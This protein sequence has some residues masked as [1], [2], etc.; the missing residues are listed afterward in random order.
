MLK[1]VVALVILASL[2]FWA[3]P[4]PA[5]EETAVTDG[6]K[7]VGV[8]K[9]AGTIPESR[10]LN[11]VKDQD[12][13]GTTLFSD[14]L[15]ISKDKLVKSVVVSIEGISKGKKITKSMVVLDNNKCRF[16]PHAQ[17]AVAGSEIDVKNSDP[18]LHNTHAYLGK[19]TV[20]NL[21]LPN[22]GQVIKKKLR[23]QPGLVTVKCDAHNWMSAVI[24]TF[25][26]PYFSISDEKGAF[27]IGDIPPGKY[28]LVAWHEIL[29]TQQK[30]ITVPAKGEVKVEFTFQK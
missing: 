10:K 5:Y 22:Q 1:M 8:V 4:L 17:A 27:D 15:V 19:I 14:E 23:P 6:G 21:A 24:P 9:F 28:K 18:K 12:Y 29:G 16:Q 30:E 20:F 26:H 2:S 25:D 11:V 3:V 13:C 7:V